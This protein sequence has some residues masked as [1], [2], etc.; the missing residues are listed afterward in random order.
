[1]ATGLYTSRCIPV[2]LFDFTFF[3]KVEL[4]CTV[5]MKL[6]NLLSTRTMYKIGPSRVVTGGSPAFGLAL[7]SRAGT[8][9]LLILKCSTGTHLMISK[10]LVRKQIGLKK[11]S[12]Y[13]T[14]HFVML[15]LSQSKYNTMGNSL[16]SCNSS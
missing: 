3:L 9:F 2:C 16:F 8:H 7:S 5:V 6:T 4:L 14:C 10:G 13:I 1:M 12:M 15:G 11:L